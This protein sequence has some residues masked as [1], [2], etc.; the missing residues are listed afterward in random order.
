MR[1]LPSPRAAL[2]AAL[3]LASCADLTPYTHRS[4]A[5]QGGIGTLAVRAQSFNPTHA[6][7][8]SVMQVV[9]DG[10]QVVVLAPDTATLL[11]AG[12]VTGTVRGRTF[13]AAAAI[14]AADGNGQWLVGVDTSGQLY[15][16]RAGRDFERVSDRYGFGQTAVRAVCAVSGRSAGF[17]L[18]GDELAIADGQTV[19]RYHLGVGKPSGAADRERRLACGSGRAAVFSGEEVRTFDAAT[20]KVTTFAIAAVGAAF[21]G[22]GRLVVATENALYSEDK[23][24]ELE[25]RYLAR[26]HE[27]PL[28]SLTGT[29]ARIWFAAGDEL[30]VVDSTASE[31]RSAIAVTHG[32]Q[33]AATAQLIGSAT[34]DVWVL[35]AGQLR[36]FGRDDAALHPSERWAQLV[37]PVFARACTAC[38]LPDGRAGIDLSTPAAWDARR[39]LIRERVIDKRSM[40][41][42]GSPLSE[43]DRGTI[44]TW[45]D[46]EP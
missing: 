27:R 44:Q 23:S 2:A 9:D 22:H 20:R 36:R 40:P 32:T 8:E 4:G 15:R 28:H 41:P 38:H 12:A 10:N 7:I 25:L 33:L 29:T 39:A 31:A 1:F 45:L 30:G 5:R 35:T 46:S 42:A 43:A 34:G 14:A 19:T 6:P 26:D 24:G 16:L 11:R 3:G 18:A 13:P 17:L 37:A 21:D